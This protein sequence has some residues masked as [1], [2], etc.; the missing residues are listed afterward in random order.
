M[1]GPGSVRQVAGLGEVVAAM[2][3]IA[4]VTEDL[5]RVNAVIAAL[6]S[7]GADTAPAEARRLELLKQAAAATRDGEAAVLAYLEG[8]R[9]QSDL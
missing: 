7:A 1:G 8:W 2:D 4:V 3:R 6:A 5:E 9:P